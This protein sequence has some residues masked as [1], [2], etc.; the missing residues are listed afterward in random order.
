MTKAG[1]GSL[2]EF[3]TTQVQ[4]VERVLDRWVPAESVDPSSIHK[5]MRYSLFA[6]GKRIRPVLAIAAAD[7][8]SDSPNGVENAAATLELVH[9]YSLIHDDLPALDNDDLRRGRPTCHKVFGEAMAILAGD[10]LLTL[11][12]E[13]LSRM[14]LVSA[15]QKIRMV[16]ELA[17]AAGSVGGMIGGQ[18]HD[19]EGEGTH[20]SA[21]LLE[22]IHKAKTGAL[23]RASVRIGAIYAGATPEELAALSDYGEH[24]GL[25]FQIVDDVLDVE[26]SSDAL[27]KTAGKDQ[28]QQKITFPA[29]YGLARSREMAEEERRG[30]HVALRIFDDRADRLR[31]IADFIVQRRA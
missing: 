11:A 23:L 21:I 16:E 10:A 18:V 13:V 17:R 14:T 12:F 7:A 29:V 26:G 24:I 1:Q 28:A 5:A 20:P 25:A 8:V 22:A 3:L 19:I 30:A 15:E 6:G 4:A 27:G 2:Q 9:T 31:Q